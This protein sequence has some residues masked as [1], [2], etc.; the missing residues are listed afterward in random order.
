MRSIVY[1]SVASAP[2]TT[3][4][5]DALLEHSRA[6]NRRR[7]LTGVLVHRDGQFMQVLEG[8]GAEI[9]ALLTTISSDP[10]HSGVWMLHSEEIAERRFPDWWMELRRVGEDAIPGFPADETVYS[11]DEHWATPSR[12]TALLEWF[13]AR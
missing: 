4:E 13:R 1:S 3:T 5:L 6:N 2:F 11:L 8:P 7:G 12:A 9:D 10:R